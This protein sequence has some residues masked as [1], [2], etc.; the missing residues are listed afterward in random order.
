[1]PKNIPKHIAIIMDGNGRWARK[2]GMP[3]I[4]GHTAGV[5]TIRSVIEIAQESGVKILT[6]YAFSTENFSRPPKEVEGLMRLLDRYLD[7][8]KEKLIKHNVQF[9]VIG[10]IEKFPLRVQGKIKS[11]SEATKDNEGLILNLALGYGSRA[12]IVQAVRRI[13]EDTKTGKLASDEVN[14]ELFSS[15][16]YTSDL[17]DPELLIRT[18]GEMRIS[19]FLLW[20]LSYAEIYITKKLWPDFKKE[21]FK[22]ALEAYSQ[23]ERRFGK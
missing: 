19:N 3:N 10:N 18:S 11:M 8:E 5:D 14:E 22:K 20:Q 16:L 9:R 17:P 23:R 6:L 2:R 15:Y 21:D 7:E 1:M 13:S 4:V 12:E